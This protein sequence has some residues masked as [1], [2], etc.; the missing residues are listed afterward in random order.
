MRRISGYTL[1]SIGLHSDR[2]CLYPHTILISLVTIE[3]HVKTICLYHSTS[4]PVH[5]LFESSY[6][7]NIAISIQRFTF[8]VDGINAIASQ[9]SV[10]ITC[11]DVTSVNMLKC[12][13]LP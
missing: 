11:I 6:V 5:D 9:T 1:R 10:F 7:G 13:T 8:L 4:Y 2:S 3:S 12:V